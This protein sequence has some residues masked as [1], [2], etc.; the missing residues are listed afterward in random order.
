MHRLYHD[1]G[2][3]HH[4]ADNQYEGEECQHV[5]READGI[6][7]GQG[8]NQGHDDGD[9]WNDGGTPAA[10]EQPYHEDDQQ[11]SF[12]QRLHHTGYRCIKEVLFTLQVLDDNA[13]W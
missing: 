8:G 6:D 12:E 9:G 4:R 2:I 11:Q 13:R 3:I 10:K 1:D 5:Q 7:D